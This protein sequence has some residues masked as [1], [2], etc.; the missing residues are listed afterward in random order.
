MSAIRTAISAALF[1]DKCTICGGVAYGVTLCSTCHDR[2]SDEAS[3]SVSRRRCTMCGKPLL[4]EIE[5]YMQCRTED[6]PVKSLDGVRP[7]FPYLLSKKKLL[8]TW[9]IAGCRSLT[10]FFAECINKMYRHEFEGLPIVP[11]PPRPGKIRAVGW[12]Q[13]HSLA[14]QFRHVYGVQ[15]LDYL[16]RT[17]GLQQKKLGRKE[18]LSREAQY[19]AS[20]KLLNEKKENV[21]LHVVLLD[22]VMTTGS[23]LCTCAK[24]LKAYGVEKV[25]ALT[26]FTVP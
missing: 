3:E 21:P 23:T 26:L 9:K 14:L 16:V 4:S 22:D 5:K 25:S 18:R 11:V 1:P 24:V 8:Y 15:V 13:T 2:L 17:S 19:R 10:S 20:K 7:V 6:S 12:D